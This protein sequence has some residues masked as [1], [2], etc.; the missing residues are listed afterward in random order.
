MDSLHP[1]ALT[2]TALLGRWMDFAK[3]SLAVPRDAEGDR[4]RACV[5]AVINLQAVTFAL[6][7]LGELPVKE[8]PLGRDKAEMIIRD[9]ARKVRETFRGAVMPDSLA[10]ICADARAALKASVWAGAVELVWEGPGVFVVPGGI[11]DACVEDDAGDADVP[12]VGTL[13]VMQPGTLVMPGEPVAWWVD[14]EGGALADVLVEVMGD[15][16]AY[17]VGGARQVYRQMDDAGRIV[18]DVLAPITAEPLPGLPLLVPLLESGR[19]I[20][21]FTLNASEWEAR[22]RAAM[23]SELIPVEVAD[24]DEQ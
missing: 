14:R 8:R 17:V 16:A 10:E 9:N 21:H 5:P 2:W 24:A 23:A 3:A 7:D 15:A 18:R 4:W 1:E 6:A 20:G 11:T 13:A 22:Q 19:P 12:G